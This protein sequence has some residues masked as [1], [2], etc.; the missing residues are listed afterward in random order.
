MKNKTKVRPH[1]MGFGNPKNYQL[2]L[3]SWF[4]KSQRQTHFYTACSGDNINFSRGQKL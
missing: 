3:F 4:I 2:R 1:V